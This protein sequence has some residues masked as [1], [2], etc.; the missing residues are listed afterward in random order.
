MLSLEA[1]QQT[2]AQPLTQ[3]HRILVVEDE[4]VIRQMIILALED[5]GYEVVV[6]KDGRTALSL[7]E[8]AAKNPSHSPFDLVV[9]DL[10]EFLNKSM[11]VI[12]GR[13]IGF[14]T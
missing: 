1:P 10:K 6:A 11:M 14:L 9:L 7:L 13:L 5:E 3:T 8:E 4:D 12:L 2:S